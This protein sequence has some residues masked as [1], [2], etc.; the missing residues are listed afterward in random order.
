MN[1]LFRLTT[2]KTIWSYIK[3]KKLLL[4]VN[5]MKMIFCF[6]SKKGFIISFVQLTCDWMDKVRRP[7]KTLTMQCVVISGLRQSEPHQQGE[8]VVVMMNVLCCLALC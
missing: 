1:Q 8:N 6:I 5:V 4:N 2:L 7:V 3:I